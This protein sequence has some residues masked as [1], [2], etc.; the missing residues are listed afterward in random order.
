MKKALLLFLLALPA[1]A[2]SASQIPAREAFPSDY[3]PS[4]CAADPARVCKS[5]A[6]DRVFDYGATLRGFDIKQAWLDGHWDE[7]LRQFA[8]LCTKI[9]NC[10]TVKDNTW[11]WCIDLMRE[12]FLGTCE[13]FPDGSEDRTQCRMVATVYFI[14]IANVS[15]LYKTSQ[16][17]TA[18]Q[19]SGELRT[20]EAWIQPQTMDLGYD[21]ELTVFAYDAETHIPV[22]ASLSVDAGKVKLT[23]GPAKTGTLLGW[24]SSLKRVTNAGKRS[25]IV[26]PTATLEATGYKPLTIPMPIEVPTAK[27]EITPPATQLKPGAN[28]IT[29]TAVDTATG[30]PVELR[31]MAGDKVLGNTNLPL[32]LDLER[33]KKRP[34]IWV[35]SLFDQYSDMVVAEK[36]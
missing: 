15:D 4:P 2:Q 11:V 35:T 28:T 20:L 29:V 6:K 12:D 32:R 27:V 9:A 25:E 3:T 30:N 24:R 8:P 23:D 18:G 7:M 21:G 22:R 34:E 16:E 1:L 17:C 13:R 26:C 10:F 19:N 36:Q 14:G 33:G 31:V 5:I